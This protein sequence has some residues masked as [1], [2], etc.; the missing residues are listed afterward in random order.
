MNSLDGEGDADVI[1]F[2]K[3][4]LKQEKMN[5]AKEWSEKGSLLT[6]QMIWMTK[7]KKIIIL[8]V[9]ILSLPRGFN[10]SLIGLTINKMQST[11]LT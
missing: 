8:R 10:L 2:E 1:A 5:R 6:P 9:N 7:Y 11:F 3:A 4:M